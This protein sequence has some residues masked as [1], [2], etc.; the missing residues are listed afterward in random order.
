[1]QET[2]ICT[3]C[4]EL[5]IPLDS[6]VPSQDGFM[7]PKKYADEHTVARIV[8]IAERAISDK[9]PFEMVYVSKPFD[10]AMEIPELTPELEAECVTNEYKLGTVSSDNDAAKKILHMY[11]HWKH[12][13]GKTYV[14]DKQT[15]MWSPDRVVH[16]RVISAFEIN[17]HLPSDGDKQNKMSYGSSLGL[18]NKALDLLPSLCIDDEWMTRAQS[19]SRGYLLFKNGTYCFETASFRAIDPEHSTNGFDPKIAFFG[20]IHR[21]YIAASDTISEYAADIGRRLFTNTLGDEAGTFLIQIMARALSG[22]CM[23]KMVFGVGTGDSGKGVITM[24]SQYALGDYHGTY[25]GDDLA[26]GTSG[27]DSGQKQRWMLLLRYKRLVFSNE[28]NSAV[29]LNGNIIKRMSAGGD[30]L[31]GREHGGNETSFEPHFTPFLLANDLPGITPCDD[32]VCTRIKALT[33]NRKFVRE[34][35]NEY[36]LLADPNIKTE[37]KTSEFQAAF[38]Q[39]LLSSHASW[40]NAGKNDT[41]PDCVAAANESWVSAPDSDGKESPISRFLDRFALTGEDADFV[42]VK[43]IKEHLENSGVTYNK[44]LSELLKHCQL[45]HIKGVHVGTRRVLGERCRGLIG[46]THAHIAAARKGSGDA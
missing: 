17:L 27:S 7:V 23:K 2:S 32:A 13:G 25:N 24:A 43:Q 30:A 35:G 26:N 42:S 21:D 44:L 40:F 36:E 19:S 4:D 20:R 18:M 34:P 28:L 37:V 6:I 10:E 41:D 9:F 12:C 39:L 33:F 3:V 29:T 8:A 38:V 14:F 46:I 16:R 1:M 11:P 22:E 31:V 5:K 45:S 15:G